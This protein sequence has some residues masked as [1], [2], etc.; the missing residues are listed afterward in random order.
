MTLAP[1]LAGDVEVT[2]E[3]RLDLPGASPRELVVAAQSF[4]N[5]R[6][7]DLESS[8]AAA[9][10]ADLSTDPPQLP[11]PGPTPERQAAEEEGWVTISAEVL[12]EARGTAERI[13][14]LLCEPG[15]GRRNEAGIYEAGWLPGHGFGL[16]ALR[17]EILQR[18]TGPHVVISEVVDVEPGLRLVRREL[19]LEGEHWIE[20]HLRPRLPVEQH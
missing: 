14:A 7:S 17:Y 4:M 20:F 8:M 15:H 9:F 10:A 11:R 16:G 19:S 13:W 18:E 12:V 3:W 2:L 5:Q 1:T 6:T